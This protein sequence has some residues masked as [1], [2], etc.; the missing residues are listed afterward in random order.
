MSR[1]AGILTTKIM[2][3]M[4]KKFGQVLTSRQG[5]REAYA[6]FL[7]TLLGVGKDEDVA[8]DFDE[9][10]AFSPSWGDEFLT[11]LIEKFGERLS[12]RNTKNLSVAL[13]LETLEGIHGY[14]FRIE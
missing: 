11:P 12:L 7:P 4:I 10:I 9:A 8:V 14:K 6:A 13:T 1:I 3:I 5:G 2:I